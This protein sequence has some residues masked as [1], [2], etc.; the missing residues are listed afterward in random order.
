MKCSYQIGSNLD[1]SKCVSTLVIWE[2]NTCEGE[3]RFSSAFHSRSQVAQIQKGY[4][5]SLTQQ[6]L[7]SDVHMFQVDPGLQRKS[8]G[9]YQCHLLLRAVILDIDQRICPT[10]CH[11][12]GVRGYSLPSDGVRSTVVCLSCER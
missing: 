2:I 7:F 9:R 12:G 3:V 1:Q 11:A 8:G 6:S 4:V 5:R 10:V